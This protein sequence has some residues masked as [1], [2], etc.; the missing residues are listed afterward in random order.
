MLHKEKYFPLAKSDI[1]SYSQS[2]VTL[3]IL[4]NREQIVE[5]RITD[6][7]YARSQKSRSFQFAFEALELSPGTSDIF[8]SP[9]LY[10]RS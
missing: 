8:A 6:S 10:Y 7:K 2:Q 3:S 1:S 9:S 5:I 4:G